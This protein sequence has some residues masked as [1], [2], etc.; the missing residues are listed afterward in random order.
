MKRI[1]ANRSDMPIPRS[2]RLRTLVVSCVFPPE[3]VVSARTSAELA[4]ELVHRGHAVTV[5]T[6]FPNRPAGKP[7]AGYIR[8]FFSSERHYSGITLIRCFSTF[9]SESRVLSR[10]LQ[11]ASFGL[12]SACAVLLARRPDVIYAN[13]WA[14]IARGL[15]ATVAKLRRIPLVTSVQDM[16]PEVLVAQ[17]RLAR[18]SLLARLMRWIDSAIARSSSH[19]CVISERFQHIYATERGVPPSRLAL[20]PNWIDI[21]T[22]DVGV[23]RDQFR[24]GRGI[25]E[26]DFLLVYGGNVGVAAGVEILIEAMRYLHDHHRIRLLIA[27]EGTQLAACRELSRSIPEERV[28]LHS[29]W[30]AEETSAV[31]RAA[32]VLLLSTQGDQS[33][34]SVPSKL[35]SY[36]L[37]ARPVIATAVPGSDL[38]RLIHRSQCGWVVT[39]DRPDLLAAKIREVA[40]LSTAER[41]QRGENGRNYVL[42]HFAKDVCLPRLTQIL[43]EAA[44]RQPGQRLGPHRTEGGST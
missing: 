27:G 36:M 12:T 34:V 2:Q 44:M 23:T 37:A 18:A 28:V 21:G 13:T 6:G 1:V 29:P 4:Q 14:I 24:L 40:R 41:Q 43:E 8:K 30:L 26:D 9:S 15:L 35:L 20:I 32:D 38:D 17:H 31:L 5:I 33:L 39:P 42:Q 22:V 7:Y 3:P 11:N 19:V 16:Y 25:S 10:A